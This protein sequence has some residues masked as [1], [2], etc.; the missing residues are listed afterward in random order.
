MKAA[1][2]EI[3]DVLNG[4]LIDPDSSC[5]YG[6]L[7]DPFLRYAHDMPIGLPRWNVYWDQRL[8]GY[9]C[10]CMAICNIKLFVG[11]VICRNIEFN[12]LFY[13][14]AIRTEIHFVVNFGQEK[15]FFRCPF[16]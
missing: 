14:E 4:E 8:N 15:L 7:V 13:S 16:Q 1:L 10:S 2:T 3:F 12:Q 11:I 5:V 9:I 6:I